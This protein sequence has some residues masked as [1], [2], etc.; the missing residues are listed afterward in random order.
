MNMNPY[1]VLWRQQLT[2]N[3]FPPIIKMLYKELNMMFRKII[4]VVAN[5]YETTGTCLIYIF[6]YYPRPPPK[7]WI[8]RQD[9]ACGCGQVPV[10]ETVNLTN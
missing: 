6:V 2:S 10:Y 8:V 3:F 9:S 5:V 4:P 7:T 1:L